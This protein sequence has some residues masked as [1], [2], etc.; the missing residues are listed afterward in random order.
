V[1]VKK[2]IFSIWS[3]L[4]V[5]VVSI[6]ILVPGCT[7]TTGTIEV[8]ATL[9]G[10]A[11]PSSGTG[12]VDYTLTG[13]GA[14]APTILNGTKVPDSFTGDPGSW[15]CAYVSGGPAAAYFVNITPSPQPLTLAAGGT[16]TFTLNF[17]TYA[18]QPLDAEIE[19]STWTIN[20]VPVDP[21]PHTIGPNTIIDIEYTEHVSGA[22]GAHVIVDQVN[23]LRFHYTGDMDGTWLHVVNTDGAV[24]MSPSA[25]KLYQD[26]TVEG[27]VQEYCYEFWVEKCKPVDLDVE[28]GWELVVCV[29]YTKSINWLGI[30]SP[31]D[32]L[33][34]LRTLTP[35]PGATFNLTAMA[36]IDLD[37]DVNP[38]NDCT[39]WC[40]ALN[41]TYLP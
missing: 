24:K 35:G 38:G 11:W 20:G 6:A 7:P 13:P 18:A 30:P 17:A 22:T 4:L 5:L 10:A 41:I 29:D 31:T 40:P 26:A 16:I 28:T 36:C 37:M 14:T 32:I 34:D 23:W 1:N 19:F 3:V 9:D 8:N 2:K 21:G 33:F 15:T 27:V 12:A 25:D 39:D